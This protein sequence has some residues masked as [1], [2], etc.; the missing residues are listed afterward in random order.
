MPGS[1]EPSC[2]RSGGQDREVGRVLEAVGA[3][4]AVELTVDG[5]V[6]VGQMGGAR[7]SVGFWGDGDA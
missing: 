1:E 4:A 6:L 5:H 3:A 7:V 2:A